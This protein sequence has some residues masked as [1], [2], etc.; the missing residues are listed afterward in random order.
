MRVG[1]SAQPVLQLSGDW[2]NIDWGY[3]YV[4]VEQQAGLQ[5][6]MWNSTVRAQWAATA[7]LPKTDDTN[8]PRAC[9]DEWIVLAVSWD[10]GQ[11]GNTPISNY[12]MIAYDDIY[13]IN[14]LGTFFPPYWR[15]LYTDAVDL[16]LTAA[17]QYTS[18]IQQTQQFDQTLLNN[19]SVNGQYYATIAS[20]AY[21][22]TWGG[23]KIVWNT[24]KKE[25]YV[26]LKEI[27]SDGN[28]NTVDVLMPASPLFIYLDPVYLQMMIL[29][30]FEYSI[31][32]NVYNSP[33]APHHLGEY[34]IGEKIGEENMPIEETGNLVLMTAA[35]VTRTE[36]A[37]WFNPVYWPL[38]ESWGTYL[39]QNLPYP[40]N[41]LCTDDFEG[42][43]PNNTNLA[44][45]GIIALDALAYLANFLGNT[46][47]AQQYHN[48]AIN[49][50]QT[51]QKCA[52]TTDNSP[53][54][55]LEYN[56]PNS[57]SD[58]YNIVYQ[59]ILG[60]TTFP[61]SIINAESSYYLL[62]F[63]AYG[64]PLDDRATFAKLD[65]EHWIAALTYNTQLSQKIYQTVYD[66]ANTSPSRVP[67]TDWYYTDKDTQTGF[68]ARP[69]VGGVYAPMIV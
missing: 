44:A 28:L 7:Q 18:L 9:S 52:Y 29:P 13:S 8:K 2:I 65:W 36:D 47:L 3:V 21:R 43:S 66:F 24:V 48:T 30:V 17:N 59:K 23:T 1:T 38:L 15:T 16:L 12:V 42:P 35:I 61:E 45:K 37:S 49:Y 31:N 46:S 22:Q 55:G 32:T 11:V 20:L 56:L 33:F 50:A 41:Q 26:F 4:G 64:L 25:K 58:K 54:Y 6:V 19:V 63:N 39:T 27:S 53:H 57:W 40:G 34:P 68:Q 14:W 67:L 5:T 62:Q 10:Y 69:V 51:W 60:L